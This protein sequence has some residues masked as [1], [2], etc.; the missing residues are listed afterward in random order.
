[1]VSQIRQGFHYQY[2][3]LRLAYGLLAKRMIHCNLQVTYRC[4][5]KC[6]I[7]DFWKPECDKT[8]ELSLDDIRRIGR[9]LN[10]LGTLIVSLAGGEPLMRDDLAG[11][12]QILNQ[13]N[14]FPILI[15]NGW[16]VDDS[17]A[18]EIQRAGLQEISVSVDYAD[19]VKHDTLRGQ[20]GAWE[21][22]V[23]ALEFLNKHR[24]TQRNR[25]HMISVLM[26]DNLP[27]VEKLIKLSRELG[28]TYMVNLYSP[29]RGTKPQRLPSGGVTRHLLELKRRYPEFITLTSYL[30]QFDRAI[31][32]G[33]IG[34]CQTG[35]LLMN[36]DNHGNVARCTETLTEPVGNIL[37]DDIPRI[38]HRLREIQRTQECAACWTSCRGFAECMHKP[39]RW[40]QFKE[41]F[42]SVRPHA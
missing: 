1:M 42:I 25:V 41:F 7:C 3:C 21:Q 2:R 18:R 9:E 4:N 39:P 14:H 24:P 32:V 19:S 27:D 26:D 28:V 10:R 11:I 40:R 30:E 29:N 23:R 38:H 17:R 16:L 31:A 35:R 6:Q 13:T 33:G 5:F 12:I 37:T 34:D 20:P 22:A 15:T 36:I 8:N